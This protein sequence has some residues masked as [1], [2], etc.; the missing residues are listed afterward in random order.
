VSN[1]RRTRTG[2]E[3]SRKRRCVIAW[4]WLLAVLT[5]VTPIGA[6]ADENP[7]EAW[8][9]LVTTPSL[10]RGPTVSFPLPSAR[11]ELDGWVLRSERFPVSVH[12]APSAPR[13]RA[14]RALSA[15]EAAY[16]WA[17]E[18]GWALPY[19]DGGYGG[20]A[21]FDVY[22]ADDRTTLASAAVDAPLA[23]TALDAATS[24]AVMDSSV[25][26]AALVPCAVSALV[27]AGL[28]AH[29]PAEAAHAGERAASAA[30]ATWQA[31]GELGCDDARTEAQ[32]AANLGAVG[33]REEQIVSLAMLLAM[34]S[35]RHDGGS[36]AFV[37][38]IW[39]LAEQHSASANALHETPDFWQAL[40]AALERAGDSLDQAAS[41]F[42]FARYAAGERT[43]DGALPPM[44]PSAKVPVL[45]AP[46][47]DALPKHLPAH[48]PGLG[49]Y[50]S[51][52]ASVD[53]SRA[54]AGAQ[55]HVWLRGD[56]GARW[57][58]MT[59]RLDARGRELGRVAAPARR[60][61]DSYVPLELTADTHDVLLVVTALPWRLPDQSTEEDALAKSTF[62]L[63]L[64]RANTPSAKAE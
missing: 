63:I 6:R 60:V 58:L 31:T 28:L 14:E 49:T 15:I 61:P 29:D 44:P 57:S 12:L 32:R 23:W 10:Y 40:A 2:L 17:S 13:A 48:A 27:Q 5:M 3:P 20:S 46:A 19:P 50:G 47:F 55:L 54:P 21:D 26:D 18:H 4:L 37:R 52:Y 42:A 30:F 35:Q 24:Y 53:V 41:E 8:A 9:K 43:R 16:E 11:P 33:T 39:E 7:F 1:L 64:D 62:R 22:L 38:G 56:P 59:V 45:Q 25:S 36:G 34:L 51:A